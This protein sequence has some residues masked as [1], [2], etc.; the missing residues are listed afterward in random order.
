M[1]KLRKPDPETL[2]YNLRRIMNDS[3]LKLP[4]SFLVLDLETTGVEPANGFIWQIGLYPVMHGEPQCDPVKGSTLYLKLEEN[5]LRQATFEISRRRA[6]ALGIPHNPKAPVNRED[7]GYKK[8]EAE[9]IGE[10]RSQGVDPREGLRTITEIVQTFVDGGHPIVM[11]NG[12]KFDLPFI[13]INCKKYGIDFRFPEDGLVDTGMLIKA[14]IL[15]RRILGNESCRKF[16]ARVGEERAYGVYFALERFCI[17]YWNMELK[18]NV[19]IA[20]AHDAGYDCYITKLVFGELAAEAQGA[21]VV[22][23]NDE[24]EISGRH[25]GTAVR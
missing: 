25:N 24:K 11:Q 2:Q 10:V 13:E 23:C 14:A 16:Y 18:Y 3:S 8:A 22:G 15:K 12:A 9:F 5:Q 19:S 17:P 20:Q 4:D 21:E 7:A 1:K 6:K